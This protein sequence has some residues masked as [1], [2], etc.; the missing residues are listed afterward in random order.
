M[1]SYRHS[2]HAGNFADLLKHTVLVEILEYMHKKDKPFEYIDTHSGA[3]L[4]HLHSE[5]AS[6]LAEYKN[7]IACINPEAWPELNAYMALVAGHNPKGG[8]DYYPGSPLVASRYIRPQ[9][10]AWCYELH[11]ADYETLSANIQSNK[12]MRVMKEDGHKGLLAHLPPTARRAVV[13]MDPSYEVK[14]EYD[15]V[16]KTLIAAH[17]KFP[18]G[19]YA[20]WYPVVQRPQ[21]KTL[22]KRMRN[23][24]IRD[25]Q[26]FELGLS[27]DSHGH[28]MSS[29]G[30]MVINAP[31]NLF[32]T[33]QALLPRLASTLSDE[34]VFKCERWVDE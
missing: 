23:S 12:R 34:G 32:E 14:T 9:D 10:R 27:A 8:L 20:L 29:S 13:L 19:I 2:Y 18:N 3:G 21:I 16:V 11:P 5:H 25:V 7:G 28:G 26:C 31:W 30:M 22:E 33:M 6:K 24:G 17:K 1:L 4:Y 15:E